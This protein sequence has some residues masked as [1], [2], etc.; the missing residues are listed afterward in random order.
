M[1]VN[2]KEIVLKVVEQSRNDV[3]KKVSE[4]ATSSILPSPDQSMPRESYMTHEWSVG[5]QSLSG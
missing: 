4:F 2:N 3:M 5:S 1:Y